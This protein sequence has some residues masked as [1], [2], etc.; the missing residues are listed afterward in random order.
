MRW[1]ASELFESKELNSMAVGCR[2]AFFPVRNMFGQGVPTF[3]AS[4]RSDDYQSPL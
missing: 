3:K 4:L 2:F 1:G